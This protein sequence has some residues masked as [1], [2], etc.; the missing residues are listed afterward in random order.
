[1]HIFGIIQRIKAILAVKC[2]GCHSGDCGVCDVDYLYTAMSGAGRYRI[3][4]AGY[5]H[6]VQVVDN[7]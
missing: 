2:S 1:M 7:V 3:R 5:D 4:L 6:C